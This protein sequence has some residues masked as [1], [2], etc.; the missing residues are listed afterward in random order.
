[1]RP[2]YK[3]YLALDFSVSYDQVYKTVYQAEVILYL[4]LYQLSSK[5]TRQGPCGMTDRQIYQPIERFEIMPL[6]KRDCWLYNW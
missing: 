1:V 5:K 3:D 2:Q 6:A 4:P